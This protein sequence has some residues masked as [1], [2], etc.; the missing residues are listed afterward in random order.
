MIIGY[1]RILINKQ[2][3]VFD[4]ENSSACQ[5][6]TWTF[7]YFNF[8]QIFDFWKFCSPIKLLLCI[9]WLCFLLGYQE[10]DPIGLSNYW[11]ARWQGIIVRQ[12]FLQYFCNSE[13]WI[14]LFV[15]KEENFLWL[16]FKTWKDISFIPINED[17]KYL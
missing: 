8:D 15:L 13:F 2:T 4:R 11:Y 10:F 17:F 6:A 3:E 14:I 9:V 1:S 12:G 7:S 5:V 16:V